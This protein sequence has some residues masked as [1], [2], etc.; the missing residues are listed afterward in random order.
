MTVLDG[1]AV[2]V[3]AQSF[4]QLKDKEGEVVTL[5][6]GVRDNGKAGMLIVSGL[7]CM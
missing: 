7:I 2:H 3:P 5:S 4:V 6:V 1:S